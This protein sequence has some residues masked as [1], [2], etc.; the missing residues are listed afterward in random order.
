[1]YMTEQK[2]SERFVRLALHWF[3]GKTEEKA[4]DFL[5]EC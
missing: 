3:D 1:M 5:I 2:S 4:Y